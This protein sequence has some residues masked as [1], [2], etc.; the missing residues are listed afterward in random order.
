VFVQFTT[1]KDSA[2]LSTRSVL[3]MEY[4]RHLCHVHKNKM[5]DCSGHHVR[6]SKRYR[7][8][9]NA[10]LGGTKLSYGRGFVAGNRQLCVHS[11]GPALPLFQFFP[12]IEASAVRS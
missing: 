5:V 12:F 8:V 2:V 9:L 3:N 1:P 4:L 6:G 10:V 7:H 11:Q